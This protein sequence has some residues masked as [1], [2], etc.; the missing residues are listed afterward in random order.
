MPIKACVFD[1]YGTLF[2]VAAA[3]RGAAAAPGG[4]RLAD[5]W[6]HLAEIWRLKQ[7]EYSWLR[8][9]ADDYKPFWQVTQDGLDYALESLKIDDPDMRATLLGLYQNLQAYPEV[10]ELLAGLKASG[11]QTGILSNGSEDM[12]AS[13]VESAGLGGVLDA[14]L[15][16]E[17]VGVFKPHRKVYD[18]VG[19]RMN[20]APKEVAF[21]SSNCWDATHAS[22][23]G[24]QTIWVNRAGAPLDR[25][26]AAPSHVVSDLS[27]A[28]A[29]V[30]GLA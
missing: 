23:Y 17:E 20:V 4:E 16:V 14:V 7:L 13:A 3:A 21:F 9:V 15:S 11:Y 25:V 19:A 1:A 8:A 10:P 26:G 5:C 30:G 28:A 22:A 29:L 24:F 27:A 18:L 12:L 6:P 2:D